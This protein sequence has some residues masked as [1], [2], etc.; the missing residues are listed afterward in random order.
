MTDRKC[1]TCAAYAPQGDGT[2]RC[3]G[4]F[5]QRDQYSIGRFCKMDADDWCMQWTP[6]DKPSQPSRILTHQQFDAFADAYLTADGDHRMRFK[7]ALA[8]IGITVE[9][10]TE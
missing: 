8:T 3:R 2:M 6:R 4:T 1:G 10:D 7:T 9:G 5:P